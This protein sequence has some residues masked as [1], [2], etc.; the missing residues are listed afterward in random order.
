MILYKLTKTFL[1]YFNSQRV[2]FG[3]YDNY[4]PGK[5]AFNMYCKTCVLNFMVLSSI[6]S[7][8]AN[9]AMK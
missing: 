9:I 8:E 1:F 2:N 3:P 7:D 6:Q 5:K 4:I